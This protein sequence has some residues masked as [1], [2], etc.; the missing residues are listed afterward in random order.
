MKNSITDVPGI[1]V[2]HFTLAAGDTQTGVT[3][4]LPYPL[5]VRNRKLF[6]GSFAS[7]NWNEW[8][9]LQVAQDFGTFS[10]PIVLC[11]S[12]AVGIVYDA[13]IS[14]GH[15]RD[16]GLPIDNAWPPMVI[17]LDDGYLNDL[18]QRRLTHDQVLQ[19]IKQANANAVACG[20]V[21]IGRGLCALGAKGGIGD[22]SLVIKIDAKEY[23][24]GVL[25]AANGGTIKT[26]KNPRPAVSLTPSL[27]VIVATDF[28]LLPE[29]LRRLAEAALRGLDGSVD[30]ND[31]TQQLALAFST[32]N[33]ID[34]AFERN[35]KLFKASLPG[36][37]VLHQL[38]QRTGACC[39]VAL[40]RALEQQEIV[41][42]RKGRSVAP[43]SEKERKKLFMK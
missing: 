32:S 9:G 21:G 4:I 11:N 35:A 22:A 25:I 43:L 2:G 19:V 23:T 26:A 10:S 7:G 5:S 16:E 6:I 36:A 17:G 42:G 24:L 30:W 40:R 14:F 29:Q 18:R 8:T 33:T 13:L 38:A 15:E 28:P 12:T 1:Q 39:G 31:G 41:A 37:E 34:D 27:V 20:S 3:A